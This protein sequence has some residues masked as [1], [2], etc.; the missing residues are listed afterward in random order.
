MTKIRTTISPTITRL[1]AGGRWPPDAGGEADDGGGDQEHAVE[2]E[3]HHFRDMPLEAGVAPAEAVDHVVERLDEHARADRARIQLRRPAGVAPQGRLQP[4]GLGDAGAPLAL[5]RR[6]DGAGLD[7]LVHVFAHQ[8]ADLVAQRR[9]QQ[10]DAQVRGA[11]GVG[12]VDHLVA[13]AVVALQR[14]REGEGEEK[15]EEAEGGRLGQ[16][17][18]RAE[19]SSVL[20]LMRMPTR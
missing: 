3:Q 2:K 12:L 5:A 8:A 4:A 16:V 18:V 15:G 7:T 11:D 13:A 20:S 17:D 6:R 14:E 9:R 19:G 10:V 1:T